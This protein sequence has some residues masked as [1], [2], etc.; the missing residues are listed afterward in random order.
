M[1]LPFSCNMRERL[2]PMT[3]SEMLQSV[4][5]DNG[6]IGYGPGWEGATGGTLGDG[7]S[8]FGSTPFNVTSPANGPV[9]F[10]NL[11]SL[12]EYFEE[13]PAGSYGICGNGNDEASES[14]T[15]YEHDP[16]AEDWQEKLMDALEA[17]TPPVPPVPPT[18][19]LDLEINISGL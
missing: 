5:G 7:F 3:Y 2:G 12:I 13:A 15:T 9:R 8:A 4:F 16:D 1:L 14:C 19:E 11:Q 6:S 10:D 17:E 18:A